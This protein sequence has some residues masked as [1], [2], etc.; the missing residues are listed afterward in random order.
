MD[1]VRFR[2]VK[3]SHLLLGVA[4]VA[5]ALVVC[6]LAFRLFAAEDGGTGAVPTGGAA[7]EQDVE[8][9]GTAQAV[10]ASSAGS[11]GIEI[12]VLDA[13]EGQAPTTE[14]ELLDETVPP[15]E[16]TAPQEPAVSPAEAAPRVLIY[17]T[18]THEA[19]EPTESDPYEALEAWRTAD[20]EHS[21]VRVGEELAKLL[22]AQGCEVVHDTT[23]HELD[24][25]S[26]AYVRSEATLLTYEE[27]FDLYIDLHR[28][29]YVEGVGE[30]A[31]HA[32]GVDY[33]KLMM[34]IGRGDNFQVKP[35]FEE[36]YAFARALTD[37]LN[38]GTPGICRDVLVKTNRYN[39]H[40]GVYSILVEVGNNRNTLTEALNSMR[41]LS[42]AIAELMTR[43]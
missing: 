33:A 25:L 21:V 37:A 30:N 5:L 14:N 18:H 8:E 23:D 13:V 32:D 41:P 16:L 28:D 31:L 26:T 24:D 15:L 39:Q 43:E 10:F 12:T 2:V 22:R 11:P 4:A 35:H 20:E 1:M 9:A 27:P 38:E 36:N 42:E 6:L 7:V 34:L 17:H 40:I 29:A 19:Y 3:G